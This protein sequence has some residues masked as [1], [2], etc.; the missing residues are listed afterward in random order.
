[1]STL[2]TATIS[3]ISRKSWY[4]SAALIL[5][6][7]L[8]Q[9]C[10]GRDDSNPSPQT[11]GGQTREL[12]KKTEQQIVAFC[13][14]CHAMPDPATFPR[15]AWRE[16][17]E[18]GY[19]LFFE[20]EREDLV[21]PVKRDTFIYFEDRAPEI[22]SLPNVENAT[23]KFLTTF[24][25]QE[26]TAASNANLPTISNLKFLKNAGNLGSGWLSCDMRFGRLQWTEVDDPETSTLLA[27][28]NNPAHVEPC[29]LDQDGKV[30]FV[31]ADLGSFLPADH[32]DGKVFWLNQNEDGQWH[33]HLLMEGTGRVA[34]VQPGDFNDDGLTDLVVAEFG[35]RRGGGIHLLTN[36]SELNGKPQFNATKIDKRHGTIHVPTCDLNG[37]G[38]LD[39]VAIISQ[40]YEEVVA[41]LNKGS[42]QFEKKTVWA[43][44]DPSYGSSGIELVDLDQDG[45]LD[46]LYTNGDTF[47]SFYIKPYHSVQW[48]ENQGSFPFIRHELTKMPGVH[49]ALAGDLDGDKDLDI[50]AVALLPDKK[51]ENSE[52]LS[53]WD[54]VIVLEQIAS[55]Q[56]ARHAL[57]TGNSTH[58]CADIDDFDGDGDIDFAVGWFLD[59]E[60][61]D[62]PWM[63][64]WWNESAK[65]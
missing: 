59:A 26:V 9:G 41:F 45:D 27:K 54:S 62:D 8:L 25:K 60:A 4:C 28:F 16:E 14:G 44:T 46:V 13:G 43:A 7:L 49:R 61:K 55:G 20:S 5:S 10:G 12:D 50:V 35:W 51:I 56:F 36:S 37:D 15:E 3:R 11:N 64:I 58:A 53:Q 42:D 23:S 47:D 63:T 29:D 38:K 19:N 1:M 34:D 48:L 21:M 52:S 17:V 31:V 40:E 18:Q 57:E 6:L 30:D 32:V 24:R 39:F 22:L 33:K 65:P 2:K